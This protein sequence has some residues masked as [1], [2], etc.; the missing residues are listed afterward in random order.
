MSVT[1]ASLGDHSSSMRIP[2]CVPRWDERRA[3]DAGARWDPGREMFWWP[4]QQP[5]DT[6]WVW[7]PRKWQRNPALWPE[8]LPSTA[9]ESNLRNA[10]EPHQWDALRRHA[11]AAAGWRCEICGDRPNAPLEAHEAW[12]WDDT[13]CV[14]KLEGLLS[15]CPSCHKAHHVGLARRLGLWK[16]VQQKF[17]EVNGWDEAQLKEALAAATKQANERS[18]FGWTLDLSWLTQSNYYMVYHFARK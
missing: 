7:L 11:Y 2:L 8:M 4:A 16:D 5:T 12:S 10:V 13:W 9:W 17:F 15:L 14:Q 18:R 6:V 1:T 3:L